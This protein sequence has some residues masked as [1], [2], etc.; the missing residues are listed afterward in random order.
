MHI[1]YTAILKSLQVPGPGY[2]L[3]N[4]NRYRRLQVWPLGQ[5]GESRSKDIA[6][7]INISV[8]FFSNLGVTQVHPAYLA[9]LGFC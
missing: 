9:Q 5:I 7:L 6:R 8:L 2:T 3:N 4:L 1:V